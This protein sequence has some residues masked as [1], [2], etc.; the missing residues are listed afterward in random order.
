MEK[1]TT[2]WVVINIGHPRKGNKY[3]VNDTFSVNRSQAIKKFIDGSGH[4]WDYWK[5]KFNFRV[6]RADMTISI[7][8]G[9]I[10]IFF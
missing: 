10:P 3:I 8:P 6:V 2:G 1:L 5:K 7:S 4:D 9:F